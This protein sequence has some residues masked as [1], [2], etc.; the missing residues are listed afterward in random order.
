MLRIFP[1]PTGTSVFFFFL[2]LFFFFRA[3]RT[4]IAEHRTEMS[5]LREKYCAPGT[6]AV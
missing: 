3:T 2:F 1:I 5:D 4:V 6:A